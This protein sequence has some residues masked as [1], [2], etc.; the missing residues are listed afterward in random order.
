MIRII[1]TIIFL[2][3][4]FQ[5]F[6]Q[7]PTEPD[8]K[9]SISHTSGELDNQSYEAAKGEFED[10]TFADRL[11]LTATMLAN[12]RR[13]EKVSFGTAF[14][15]DE[16]YKSPKELNALL[17]AREAGYITFAT[18]QPNGKYLSA[19]EEK[20]PWKITTISCPIKSTTNQDDVAFTLCKQAIDNWKSINQKLD[21]VVISTNPDVKLGKPI[22][23]VVNWSAYNQ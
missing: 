3:S 18:K 23:K 10:F 7:A 8:K 13:L 20:A 5:A 4:G 1:A 2:L 14:D 19:S 12:P 9:D 15:F 17:A 21:L 11:Q 16:V 6:G 22:S